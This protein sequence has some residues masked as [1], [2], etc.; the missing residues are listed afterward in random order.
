MRIRMKHMAAAMALA[1]VATQ[2]QAQELN[3]VVVTPQSGD[4]VTI[5]LTETPSVTFSDDAVVVAGSTTT[6]EYPMDEKA[7][8]TFTH[9]TGIKALTDGQRGGLT[10]AVSDALYIGGLAAGEKVSVYNTAGQ[11]LASAK[12]SA[13]G[14]VKIDTDALHGVVI[15]KTTAKAIKI[16]LR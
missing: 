2:V 9:S 3:A 16:R 7:T 8:F 15:V 6:V 1:A 14:S 4:A 12:A 5:A 13:T 11:A 10:V